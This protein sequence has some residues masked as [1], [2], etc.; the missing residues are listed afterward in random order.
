MREHC[1][2]TIV[3]LTSITKTNWWCWPLYTIIDRHVEVC[4]HMYANAKMIPVENIL[5]IGRGGM[6]ESTGGDE[7]KYDIFDTL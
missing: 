5:R 7:F 4:I 2:L 1:K 6:E 3:L